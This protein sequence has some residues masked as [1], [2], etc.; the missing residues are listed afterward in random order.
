MIKLLKDL[1]DV[2]N[3]YEV[4]WKRLHKCEIIFDFQILVYGN[5]N[6]QIAVAITRSTDGFVFVPKVYTILRTS[7]A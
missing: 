4:N 5:G 7:M 1:W 3:W 2:Y 6:N